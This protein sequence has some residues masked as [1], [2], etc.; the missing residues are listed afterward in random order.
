M[1]HLPSKELLSEVLGGKVI[2]IRHNRNDRRMNRFTIKYIDSHD[3]EHEAGY[4]HSTIQYNIYELMHKCK[5]WMS[6]KKKLPIIEYLPNGLVSCGINYDIIT[7]KCE[8]IEY[9]DTEPEAVFKACQ[10]F[11]KAKG[12]PMNTEEMKQKWKR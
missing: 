6:S 3:L 9:G 4:K 11:L 1:K 8:L 5:E 7:E 12:Q 2:D 10:A